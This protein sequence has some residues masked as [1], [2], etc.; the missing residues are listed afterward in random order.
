MALRNKLHGQAGVLG[1]LHNVVVRLDGVL[2]GGDEFSRKRF[3]ILG[4]DLLFFVG[5]RSLLFAADGFGSGLDDRFALEQGLGIAL[6]V[7]AVFERGDDGF[8]FG[9]GFFAAL[10]G[11][12]RGQFGATSPLRPASS[13]FTARATLASSARCLCASRSVES[14]VMELASAVFSLSNAV[15]L[16]VRVSISCSRKPDISRRDPQ[17]EQRDF[18]LHAQS[19]ALQANIVLTQLRDG[20]LTNALEL[21]EMQI[22]ASVILIGSF[23]AESFFLLQRVTRLWARCGCLKAYREAHPRQREAVIEDA[24]KQDLEALVQASQKA[25]RILSDLK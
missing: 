8:A 2:A 6:E 7:R 13:L 23:F 24:D 22:D 16:V 4:A 12:V 18:L 15:M 25:S 10:D 9:H 1:Q 17:R 11:E 19:D 21:L 20:H 14:V 3:L 5:Q